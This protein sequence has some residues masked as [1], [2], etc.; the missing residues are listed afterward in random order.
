MTDTLAYF[1]YWWISDRRDNRLPGTLTFNRDSG[2]TLNL[3]GELALPEPTP[4]TVMSGTTIYGE[5]TGPAVT[6]L[7]ATA[8]SARGGGPTGQHE[9][10]AWAFLEGQ[11]HPPDDPPTFVGVGLWPEYL[12]EWAATREAGFQTRAPADREG[13]VREVTSVS[14]PDEQRFSLE[15]GELSLWWG[16][17]ATMGRLHREEELRAAWRF[18][19]KQPIGI[20]SIWRRVVRPLLY[21]QTLVTG[22]PTAIVRETLELR[23]QE[24]AN[25][26]ESDEL[27]R[28]SRTLELR[29]YSRA[30]PERSV[31]PWDWPVPLSALPDFGQAIRS[32]FDT[33]DECGRALIS[34]FEVWQHGVGSAE[35]QFLT[36]VQG[37]EGYHRL[38][39]NFSNEVVKKEEFRAR[40]DTIVASAPEVDQAWLRSRLQYS[41]EPSLRRRIQELLKYA[42]HFGSTLNAEAY[43]EQS[44]VRIRNM[45]SHGTAQEPDEAKE[46]AWYGALYW[47]T[48]KL[49]LLM[50][51]VLMR[52]LGLGEDDVMSLMMRT[53]RRA[54][55]ATYRP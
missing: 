4:G 15:N 40:L 34:L 31:R 2:A 20:D 16:T 50:Q 29:E 9:L 28:Y 41:N 5:T 11:N 42:G 8:W 6:L 17:S 55:A 54:F 27:E 14:V 37:V 19:L 23:P 3:L 1:G 7:N 13:T 22:E 49:S 46:N 10:H 25:S 45:L 12:G 21:F 43:L 36:L 52:D 38:R 32:W 53:E 47:T 26:P 18:E 48:E 39:K 30:L 51:A 33:Y 35:S 24:A 44:V